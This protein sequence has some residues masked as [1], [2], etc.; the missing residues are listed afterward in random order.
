[1]PPP[2]LGRTTWVKVEVALDVEGQM[3]L[4]SIEGRPDGGPLHV[5]L[6]PQYTGTST[7]ILESIK[8]DL[9]A[10]LN[11]VSLTVTNEQ[12]PP[13]PPRLRIVEP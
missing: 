1:M 4:Y 7:P 6:D 12:P 8:I 2:E 11:N 9:Q 13:E 10:T 3:T 5:A